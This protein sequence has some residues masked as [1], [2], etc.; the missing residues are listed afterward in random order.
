M[1]W[2]EHDIEMVVDLADRMD[3]LNY[4]S[5]MGPPGGA[6]QPRMIEAYLGRCTV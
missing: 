1:V 6:T 2:V 4:G 3:V 5:P